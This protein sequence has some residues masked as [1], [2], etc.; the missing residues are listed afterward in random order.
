MERRPP[1]ICQS[2]GNESLCPSYKFIITNCSRAPYN[3][4]QKPRIHPGLDSNS[5]ILGSGL[6]NQLVLNLSQ[7]S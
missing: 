3:F 1:C 7:R 6:Q 2:S 4:G 5:E